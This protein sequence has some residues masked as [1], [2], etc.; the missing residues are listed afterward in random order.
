MALDSLSSIPYEPSMVLFFNI[1]HKEW[2]HVKANGEMPKAPTWG[3]ILEAICNIIKVP[4]NDT[5]KKVISNASQF[6]EGY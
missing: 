6:Y 5:R 4:T 2:G 1:T 3:F